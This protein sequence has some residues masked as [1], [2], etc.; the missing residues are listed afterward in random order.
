M[1]SQSQVFEEER[2]VSL[3]PPNEIDIEYEELHSVL[4]AQDGEPFPGL[5]LLVPF[6]CFLTACFF[7]SLQR[8]KCC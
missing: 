4:V 8:P 2:I 6:P 5:T 3:L 7:L 1:N